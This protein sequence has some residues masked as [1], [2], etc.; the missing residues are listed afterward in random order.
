MTVRK[1]DMLIDASLAWVRRQGWNGVVFDI[2][3]LPP[4]RF[5]PIA[6]CSSEPMCVLPRRACCWR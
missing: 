2:E 4:A 3:N 6:P 5:P 1:T